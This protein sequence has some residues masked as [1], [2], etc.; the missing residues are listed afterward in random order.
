MNLTG[1]VPNDNYSWNCGIEGSS[2]NRG[3]EELRQ[4]QIKKTF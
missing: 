4:R 3:I 1:M 2:P